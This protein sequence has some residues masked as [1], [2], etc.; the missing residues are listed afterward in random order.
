MTEPEYRDKLSAAMLSQFAGYFLLCMVAI[1][2]LFPA[3][4]SSLSTAFAGLVAVL[5]VFLDC[6][7]AKL[8]DL[9]IYGPS[10]KKDTSEQ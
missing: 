3:L 5:L 7:R 8:T 1:H 9:L 2:R 10:P 6:N 4:E